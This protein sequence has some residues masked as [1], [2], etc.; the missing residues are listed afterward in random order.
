VELVRAT[1]PKG[2]GAPPVVKKYVNY[3]ASVRAAQFIVLSAKARA[4]AQ[5]RYHVSH[6]DLTALALPVLRHRII[7]NF[8]AD[9]DRIS[10]DEILSQLIA[11][12]PPPGV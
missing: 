8:H 11:R 7:L 1:R 6:E 5:G 2:N 10:A 3:G 9:S 12:L 4:L